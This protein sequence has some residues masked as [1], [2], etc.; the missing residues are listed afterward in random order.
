ME[1]L[2][3]PSRRAAACSG[4]ST[5]DCRHDGNSAPCLLL[6]SP[7][8]IFIQYCIHDERSNEYSLKGSKPRL[9]GLTLDHVSL[10]G[11]G[12]GVLRCP[13]ALQGSSLQAHSAGSAT[14]HGPFIS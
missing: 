8:V 12:L 11:P 6:V 14:A 1:N 3:W 4:V 10:Y 9:Q 13:T 2:N 7:A 5:F